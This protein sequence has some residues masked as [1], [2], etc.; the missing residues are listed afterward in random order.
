[1]V[2]RRGGAA[3]IA[4]SGVGASPCSDI[5]SSE[6]SDDVEVRESSESES[7]EDS[8]DTEGAYSCFKGDDDRLFWS[9]PVADDVWLLGNRIG[10]L[11]ELI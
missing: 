1:M 11:E 8:D 3:L 9:L 7:E 2:N 10:A 6:V 4:G 5:G